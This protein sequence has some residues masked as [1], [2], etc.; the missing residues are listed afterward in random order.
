MTIRKK[1]IGITA[2][3]CSIGV[4]AQETKR[5]LFLGNSY[6]YANNLPQMITN[7]AESAGKNLVFDMN[8][9]GGYYLGQHATNPVSLAKMAAGNWDNVVLQ[10][11]SLAMAYPGYFMNNIS[12]SIELDSIIKSHNPCA[13]T[14]FFATWGRKNGG[15]HLCGEPYCDPPEWIVRNYFEMDSDI[16]TNYRVFAD[17]L[18]SSMAPVGA[19]WRYIRQN[20]PSIELFEPDE[21]HPTSAGSYAA[22]CC[23]YAVIFRSDP[24]L[25]TFDGWIPASD[26]AL[27]RN[28]ANQVVYNNL[29]LNVG[30][31]DDLLNENCWK[32]GLPE[33]QISNWK[34]SPNPAEAVL[35]FEIPNHSTKGEIA[36]YNSLGI[37]VRRMSIEQETFNVDISDLPTG[38]Y[39]ITM[40]GF[41]ESFKLIKK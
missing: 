39:C 14:M 36:I 38:L 26:A 11:Q 17:S 27:I 10:D 16:E 25:I 15:T 30:L 4:S 12:S 37:L 1:F 33:K 7:A 35:R 19:V 23:F 13:Q 24:A 32:L 3:L 5:V 41:K 6:T 22:A 34:I 21:S 18:K 29:Q 8:A 28:A 40:D 9:P 20:H 31:Y 2:F